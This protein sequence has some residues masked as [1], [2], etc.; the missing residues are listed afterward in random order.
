MDSKEQLTF[1]AWTDTHF[2]Y[3]PQFA[4]NDHRWNTLQQMTQLPGWPYSPEIGGYVDSP[5]F[6]MHCGD[7][8]D[9]EANGEEALSYYLYCMKQTNLPSFETLG[10][11]D[12]AHPNVID[13]FVQKHGGKYYSFDRK[14]V[15]FVFLYQ[16]FTKE[17]KVKALDK[18]QLQWLK[19]DL[20]EVGP[21]KPV[22]LFSHDRLD[23]LPNANG[24]DSVLAKAKVILMLS[25]HNHS[26]TPAY[27]WNGRTGMV[28]G[29]CRAHPSDA[30]LGRRIVVV[31]I[32]E[33][34]L[35]VVPWRWDLQQWARHQGWKE[36]A[37]EHVV[38][39]LPL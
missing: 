4:G 15:H 9:A 33:R 30:I 36:E 14:G 25:G 31:K 5:E 35:I 28:I 37:G 21:D 39:R 3:R 13:Y 26:G 16:T 17:E 29:H 18:V 19:Q 32:T 10:N 2:G 34:E 24:V 8:V 38:K 1:F 23:N 12:L 27:T 6:I 22:V 7:L 20:S 11:H